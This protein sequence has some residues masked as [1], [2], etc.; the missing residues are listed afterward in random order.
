MA[1]KNRVTVDLTTGIG[2]F[3][4]PRLFTTTASK[5]DDGSPSYDIQ[6]LIP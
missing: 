5:K 2:T 3:S 4:F 1:D 6:F